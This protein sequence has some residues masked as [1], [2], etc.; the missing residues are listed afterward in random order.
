MLDGL[1]DLFL[2]NRN[3]KLA[4]GEVIGHPTTAPDE[5]DVQDGEA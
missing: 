3:L 2:K 1:K 4:K 5:S